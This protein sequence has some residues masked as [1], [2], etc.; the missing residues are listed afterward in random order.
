MR[1]VPGCLQGGTDVLHRRAQGRVALRVRRS[2]DK[3]REE[4]RV[5]LLRKPTPTG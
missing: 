3:R 2:S 1:G 4:E 5:S